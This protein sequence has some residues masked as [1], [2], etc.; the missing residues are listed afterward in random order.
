M[1]RFARMSCVRPSTTAAIVS[2]ANAPQTVAP[3]RIFAPLSC[4]ARSKRMPSANCSSTVDSSTR[5][6]SAGC[7]KYWPP[8]L[9][10]SSA[11]STSRPAAAATRA[12]ANP[13][14]PPPTTRTSAVIWLQLGGADS[15]AAAFAGARGGA[16]STANPAAAGSMHART[17][18]PFTSTRHSPHTPMP[19]NG[20]RLAAVCVVRKAATPAAINAAANDSPAY[21]VIGCPAKVNSKAALP[22]SMP[23][24]DMRMRRQLSGCSS[25]R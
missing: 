25:R 6:P 18:A 17:G 19:Q 11:T 3:D 7:L 16:G 13:A 10:R 2:G 12:A 1:T 4:A 8:G 14:G 22:R 9:R 20:P 21:A 24:D 23:F 5:K 15:T